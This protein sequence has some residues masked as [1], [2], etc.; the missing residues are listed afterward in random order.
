VY[1]AGETCSPNLR[2]HASAI[3]TDRRV[4]SDIF[5]ATLNLGL[6]Q[7]DGQSL[8]GGSSSEQVSRIS[9]TEGVVV[10]GGQTYSA[11]FP[12][13]TGAYDTQLSGEGNGFLLSIL[14]NYATVI[15]CTFLGGSS[16]DEA[17]GLA[18]DGGT[19]AVPAD[20]KFAFGDTFTET[21][22]ANAFERDGDR[23]EYGGPPGSITQLVLDYGKEKLIVSRPRWTWA[24]WSRERSRSGS[25]CRSGTT[26]SSRSSFAWS[27]S[28]RR[29]GTEIECLRAKL[30][31]RA[32]SSAPD[33]RMRAHGT[34]LRRS[35]RCPSAPS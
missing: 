33:S 20:V 29:C 8:Y 9:A 1:L 15:G 28:A 24:P 6:T 25:S 23:Y 35:T 30:R 17:F 31:G 18:T 11:D 13:T 5:L 2:F 27:A 14:D 10:V 22:D 12:V 19:P 34:G 16:I 26:R 4:S 32:P 3:Q 21:I 7:L